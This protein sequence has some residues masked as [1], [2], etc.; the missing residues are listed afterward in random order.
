MPPGA[1]DTARIP[2]VAGRTGARTALA[3]THPCRA[4][5][6]AIADVGLTGG[7]QVR[8]SGDVSR[9][10]HNVLR[11]DARPECNRY[12]LEVLRQPLEDGVI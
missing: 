9:A 12:V 1:L 5:H 11:L 3:T 10:H 6:P 7:G 4:P 8:R 2:R